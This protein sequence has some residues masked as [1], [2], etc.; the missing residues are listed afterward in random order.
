MNDREDLT[1]YVKV[2]ELVAVLEGQ[3][4]VIVHDAYR[5]AIYFDGKNYHAIEDIC[6]HMGTFISNGYQEGTTVVCPWH[7]WEFDLSDGKCKNPLNDSFIRAF[8]L[9]VVRESFYLPNKLS[10]ENEGE[11]DDWV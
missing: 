4:L 8:P 2:G 10:E 5:I 1:G 6:P 11:F 9:K 3:P 7:N